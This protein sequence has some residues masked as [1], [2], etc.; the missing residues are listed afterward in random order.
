MIKCFSEKY[1]NKLSLP[2]SEGYVKMLVLR[3]LT[4]TIT[5]KLIS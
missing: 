4:K 5:N 3:S 2:V 1:G